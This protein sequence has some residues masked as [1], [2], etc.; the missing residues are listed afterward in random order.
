MFHC[1]K[2]KDGGYNNITNTNKV[3]PTQNTPALQATFLLDFRPEQKSLVTHHTL[4]S[5]Y[6]CVWISDNLHVITNWY[7]RTMGQ[8]FIFRFSRR[9]WGRNTWRTPKNVCVGG[10]R[11]KELVD[12]GRVA[13]SFPTHLGKIEATLLAGYWQGGP[14][15]MMWPGSGYGRWKRSGFRDKGKI[16]VVMAGLKNRGWLASLIKYKSTFNKGGTDN[17]WNGP[18]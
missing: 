15:K 13:S 7:F 5:L 3:S 14:W 12:V 2:I 4:R 9:S 11:S 17:K 1:H 10:Y 6:V 16:L 8:E 18:I